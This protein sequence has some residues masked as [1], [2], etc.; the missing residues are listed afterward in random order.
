MSHPVD[1][2]EK[3]YQGKQVEEVTYDQAQSEI[4]TSNGLLGLSDKSGTKSKGM[5]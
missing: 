4:V 5:T 3:Q 1:M 2:A